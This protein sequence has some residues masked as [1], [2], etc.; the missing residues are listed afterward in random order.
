VLLEDEKVLACEDSFIRNLEK[1]LQANVKL[2][3]KGKN[4][5][6]MLV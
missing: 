5:L 1:L 6:H 4:K 2:L 3:T